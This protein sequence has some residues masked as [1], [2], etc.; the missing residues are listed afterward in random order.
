MDEHAAFETQAVLP[1]RRRRGNSLAVLL[2]GL[3]VTAIVGAGAL[4]GLTSRTPVPSAAPAVADASI[5]PDTPS[6]GPTAE[7]P[8]IYPRSILGLQVWSAAYVS[9]YGFGY[10][11]GSFAVAGWFMPASGTGCPTPRVAE[12]PSLALE[13]GVAADA[14]TFCRRS[15]SLFTGPLYDENV[16]PIEIEL[17]PGV[18]APPSLKDIAIV[19]PVVFVGKL[20]NPGAT[21]H[22][23][24]SCPSHMVV[25][26]V[27]WSGG[28]GQSLTTSVLPDLLDDWPPLSE[29]QRDQVSVRA[30]GYQ[31]SV[32][33]ETLVD[34]RTLAKV[35]PYAAKL[36][37]AAAPK[38]VRIWY[39]RVLGPD[40]AEDA[41]RWIAIDD[42]T[43][44]LIATGTAA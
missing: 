11:A 43:G 30:I 36:L 44:R 33:L 9:T 5:L 34:L 39:R 24:G 12:D 22:N 31:G 29:T 27:A 42:A 38:P 18:A 1:P 21:C 26:R 40:P 25:D 7:P 17:R 10:F 14:D 16:T 2:A 13:Y 8:P 41:M 35:D 20:D 19:T 23:P 32:L 3:A 6:P 4:G 28:T 15:G 37:S